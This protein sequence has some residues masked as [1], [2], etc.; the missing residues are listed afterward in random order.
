MTRRKLLKTLLLSL[1]ALAANKLFPA[2]APAP[3]PA[4]VPLLDVAERVGVEFRVL[5]WTKEGIL[6]QCHWQQKTTD[7]W[8]ELDLAR[9]PEMDNAN[10]VI[11]DCCEMP[12]R[13]DAEQMT[14]VAVGSQPERT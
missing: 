2:S 8:E 3:T 7:T 5:F 6:E 14:G 12:H 10:T 1:P 4:A 9:I 13:V 11:V